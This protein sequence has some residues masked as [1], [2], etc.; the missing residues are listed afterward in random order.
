MNRVDE[1]L[2]NV[3]QL[4]LVIALLKQTGAT[5]RRFTGFKPHFFKE[6]PFSYL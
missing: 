3:D 1:A 5:H 6:Y 2:R 4:E